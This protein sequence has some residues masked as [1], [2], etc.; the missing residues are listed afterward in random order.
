MIFVNIDLGTGF[1]APVPCVSTKRAL[2]IMN[3]FSC[4]ANAIQ[5]IDLLDRVSNVVDMDLDKD[6]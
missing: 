1:T 4:T 6:L 3:I 2:R 5:I